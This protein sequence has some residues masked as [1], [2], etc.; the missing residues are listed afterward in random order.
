LTKE[1]LVPGE[2]HDTTTPNHTTAWTGAA[3][4]RHLLWR[5]NLPI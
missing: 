4:G 5:Q 1:V 3:V 2:W